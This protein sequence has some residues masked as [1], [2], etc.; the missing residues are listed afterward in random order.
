MTTHSSVGH[1][2]QGFTLV[3]RRRRRQP[4]G[5][6]VR[7]SVRLTDDEYASLADTAHR[8]GLTPTSYVAEV[9]LAATTGN[10]RDQQPDTR[11][12]THAELA[13][14]QH[15]LFATRTAINHLAA[16]LAATPETSPPTWE[17][18]AALIAHLDEVTDRLHQQLQPARR[19]PH[20][21]AGASR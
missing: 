12:V 5:R 16:R 15:E 18:L 4:S 17:D 14:L 8:L 3:L 20:H 13:R 11:H 10:T 1:A 2:D 19:T 6:N 7:I 9:A 21:I